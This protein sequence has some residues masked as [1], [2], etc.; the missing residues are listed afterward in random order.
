MHARQLHLLGGGEIRFES[1]M[2]ELRRIALG[3]DSLG[4]PAWVDYAP[5][6]LRGE[7]TLFDRIE[8]STTWR[9][10]KRVMYQREVDVPRLLATVPDDGPGDPVFG[11]I[12]RA[13]SRRYATRFNHVHMALYRDGQDSVA[14]HSDHVGRNGRPATVAILSLGGP[15]RFILRSKRTGHAH[16]LSFGCGDLLVM[17]ATSQ[18]DWLHGVPKMARAHPRIAVMFRDGAEMPSPAAPVMGG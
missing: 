3:H 6:C 11:D 18:R 15:R 14:P 7:D 8:A 12:S 4:Q 5:R 17:S 10:H 9:T 16:R 1:A 13:L 2:T